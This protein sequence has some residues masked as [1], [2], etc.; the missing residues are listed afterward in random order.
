MKIATWNVERQKHHRLLGE[1][2]DACKSICADVLVLT[3]TDHRIMPEYRFSCHTPL[4]SEFTPAAYGK[5]ENRVSIYT[6]YP[7]V[8]QYPTYDDRTALCVE[9]ETE[10]G[11]LIIYATIMG[12]YGNRH[13]SFISDVK[14]QVKDIY[15]LISTGKAVCICGDYNCSFA[16]NY[17]F[18]KES[19]N[20][21]LRLK[22]KPAGISWVL[23]F[24]LIGSTKNGIIRQQVK[25]Q[26]Q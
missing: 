23:S 7:I 4:M 6:N 11:N 17:Y 24:F 18:T 12:V 13:A 9:L 2:L 16:D 1:M 3:E 10:N 15:N 20:I 26:L 5:T 19:R 14:A 22:T 8:R 25:E 21:L